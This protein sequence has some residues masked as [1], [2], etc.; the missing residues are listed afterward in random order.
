LT[1]IRADIETH[2]REKKTNITIKQTLH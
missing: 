1:G 2:Q